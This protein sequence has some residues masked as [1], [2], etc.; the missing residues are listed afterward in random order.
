MISRRFALITFLSISLVLVSFKLQAEIQVKPFI[1]AASSGNNFDQI[2][3]NTRSKLTSAGFE[4]LGEYSPYAKANIIVFTNKE[5]R[6]A[7]TKSERGGYGGALRVAITELEG[8]TQLSYTNPKYWSNAYQMSSNLQSVSDT[9]ASTLNAKNEFGTG[10][11]VLSESD[12]RDYHYTF[13]MEYFDDPSLLARLESHKAAVDQIEG[14]L[15]QG[16]NGTSKVYRLDLGKDTEG[17]QMTLF[18]VGLGGKDADDCSSDPYIMGR[19][20]KSSL[21]HTAHLPYELLVYGSNVEAL[22]GRFRIA[23]SWPHLPMMSSD[24]G[25]TFLS[26]MYAPGAIEEALKLVAGVE[27]KE[28]SLREFQGRD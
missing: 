19:I 6:N 21:R 1:L 11:K 27:K 23:I 3:D 20:D 16:A 28:Q 14:Y 24:T 4:I 9:L 10:E 12:M 15:S 18:G 22:Y 5:L 7:A 26:I 13:M 17:K 25:A 2:L 8:E